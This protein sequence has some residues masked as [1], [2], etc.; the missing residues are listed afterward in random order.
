MPIFVEHGPDIPERL[1]HAQE[2]GH[3]VFFCGAGISTAAGLPLFGR[4]VKQLYE[5]AGVTPNGMQAY[6][7]NHKQ[8]D[9]AVEL[10]ENV[11]VGGRKEVRKNL[12]D[13]LE[14]DCSKKYALT[15]H[16]SLLTLATDRENKIKLVTTNYDHLFNI[17]AK[18]MNNSDMLLNKIY[19]SPLLPIPKSSQWD[20]LVYLHGILPDSKDDSSKFENIVM[21]S[22][23]FGH[24]YL[25]ERWASRFI[26]ELFKNF[27]IC[28]IGYSLNDP[29]MRYMVDAIAA[30]RTSG[31]I[32]KNEFYAFAGHKKNDKQIIEDEW[33]SKNIMPI[34]YD[35][36]GCGKFSPHLRLTKS[37]KKWADIYRDGITGKNNIIAKYA[38]YTP[39][40]K[41]AK[42][43]QTVGNVLWAL[44]DPNAARFFS[45]LTPT[46]PIEWIYP[47]STVQFTA[48]DLKRFGY[49]CPENLQAENIEFSFMD[50]PANYN[51]SLNSIFVQSQWN[52]FDS[53]MDS[54]SKWLVKHI[55]K[56]ALLLWLSNYN[57]CITERFRLYLMD[58]FIETISNNDLTLTKQ[59][60][61]IWQLFIANRIGNSSEPTDI[62][63]NELLDL[64]D[65]C[66][67][68]PATKSQLQHALTPYIILKKSFPLTEGSESSDDND[69]RR[70]LSWD[71]HLRAKD[72]YS[73]IDHISQSGKCK[74]WNSFQHELLDLYVFLLKDVLDLKNMLGDADYYHDQSYFAQPSI[75]PHEQNKRYA[76]WVLLVEL[77]RN[78]WLALAKINPQKATQ[79]AV[80]LWDIP[81]PIFKRLAIFCF[82]NFAVIPIEISFK[83]LLSDDAYWLWSIE[84]KREVSRLFVAI[85]STIPKHIGNIIEEAIIDGPND[86]ILS[87]INNESERLLHASRLKWD[88]LHKL[89]QGGYKFTSRAQVI[90]EEL[91]KTLN[92]ES[93]LIDE[94]DEFVIWMNEPGL[95][96]PIKQTP[97]SC[98]DL[99]KYITKNPE[100]DYFEQQD[101]WEIRC[102]NDLDIA[103][104]A[105]DGLTSAEIFPVSRWQVLLY[106]SSIWKENNNI[107]KY[108]LKM[109]N[110][111]NRLSDNYFELIYGPLATWINNVV[112]EVK[113]NVDSYIDLCHRILLLSKKTTRYS[114]DFASYAINDPIGKTTEALLIYWARHELKDNIGIESRYQKIFDLLCLTEEEKYQPAR[115]ILCRN[116]ALF[117]RIDSPWTERQLIPLF[118][119]EYSEIEAAIAWQ[120]FLSSPHLYLP[121]ILNLKNDLL[122]TVNHYDSLGKLAGQYASLVTNLALDEKNIFKLEEI[123]N[124]FDCFS[125]DALCESIRVISSYIK[126]SGEQQM[127]M[128][129]N[130]IKP[131]FTKIWPNGR[132]NIENEQLAYTVAW[133]FAESGDIFPFLISN[134]ISKWLI[135]FN[136]SIHVA[137]KIFKDNTCKKFPK[138]SLTFLAMIVKKTFPGA[139]PIIKDCLKQISDSDQ[140]LSTDP[141]FV[142]L[143]NIAGG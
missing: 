25:T 97:K 74:K 37:L 78:A 13:I 62:Y 41:Y 111:V 128:W 48:K 43:D 53:I 54:L 49:N 140:R 104:C 84:T 136:H 59:L 69:L 1:I 71:I 73:L 114:S 96:N 28:F 27:I 16:K 106:S 6:S 47:L 19:S 20:G 60:Q 142:K 82:K 105:L 4:L 102:R 109:L 125:S 103:I 10:L 77:L 58:K 70:I 92:I 76:D 101:D 139:T 46:P 30:D 118:R 93:I 110:V 45:E 79:K 8:Y 39:L 66:G 36:R 112:Y 14:P 117:Y 135:P 11:Y 5:K 131:F 129:E 61:N 42:N 52:C 31:D 88:R 32:T 130:R 132:K 127:N 21:S 87:N 64:I 83:L 141:D 9:T 95:I 15:M 72:A 33:K 115:F 86:K 55:D 38:R 85:G 34:L 3:L 122:S 56:P 134:I 50:R 24:A 51:N 124:I 68:T 138:E 89:S 22:S 99:I 12:I 2:E 80:E 35:S 120:G 23:D 44:T 7:I 143:T 94:S 29:V 113:L 90:F 91:T 67:L 107:E 81:Y 57:L 98:N 116:I 100:I 17:A 65:K 18:N 126:A 108:Y 133:M 26:S 123:R 121:L 137:R 75:E 63:S 40:S 119:W